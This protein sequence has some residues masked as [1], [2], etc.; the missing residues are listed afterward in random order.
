MSLSHNA[1]TGGFEPPKGLLPYRFSK[2]TRSTTLPRLHI[3]NLTYCVG[4]LNESPTEVGCLAQSEA[5]L[6]SPEG[7]EPPTSGLEVRR[8]I[9]LSYGLA[10]RVVP[11]G[12]C[13]WALRLPTQDWCR[14]RGSNP[15]YPD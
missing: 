8:S 3:K 1:E 14:R 5:R 2:P 13:R 7:F 10:K 9:Q 12:F 6:A 4:Y 11:A 15:R